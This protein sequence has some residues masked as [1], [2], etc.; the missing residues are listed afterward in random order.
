MTLIELGEISSSSPEPPAAPPR[1]SDVRRFAVA[2]V[3]VLAVLTVTGSERP[4][5]RALP[6]L[7]RMP[8]GDAPFTLTADSV[9]LVDERGA[10]LRAYDAADGTPRWSR[11]LDRQTGW[12]HTD[13]PGTLLIHATSGVLAD[14]TSPARSETLAVDSGTGAVRWRQAG[15]IGVATAESVMLVEWGGSEQN[16]VRRA[17]VVGIAD[18]AERWVLTPE[19]PVSSWTVTGPA[20]ERPDRLITATAAGRLQ[21]RRFSDGALLAEAPR[22]AGFGHLFSDGPHLYVVRLDGSRQ[23]ITAYEVDTLRPRWEWKGGSGSGAQSC[24]ALLCATT[25]PGEVDA[26]DP[27]TGEVRWH[28]SG[29]DL[30]RPVGDGTLVVE[31]HQ[32]NRQ[33]LVDERTGRTVAQ[34]TGGMTVLDPESPTVL[35]LTQARELP[36]RYVVQQLDTATGEMSLRGAVPTSGDQGCQLVAKRLAC[37]GG[38]VLVVTDVG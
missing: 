11:P 19:Q 8:V 35:G 33:E 3:A 18:A 9:Y 20:P 4:E 6:Q 27:A 34:F 2:A 15:E 17:R 22:V 5:P 37:A 38:G 29:W 26:L 21:V 7:W 16:E 28:A 25:A 32:I 30:A 1:R 36:P 23:T 24:G 10:S 12:F 14:G 13:V 31:S